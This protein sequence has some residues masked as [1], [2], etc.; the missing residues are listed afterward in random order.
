MET[1]LYDTLL[2][3]LDEVGNIGRQMVAGLGGCNE[4]AKDKQKSNTIG[5]EADF[6]KKVLVKLQAGALNALGKN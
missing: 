6:L 2:N 1:K 3:F 4:L 5:D